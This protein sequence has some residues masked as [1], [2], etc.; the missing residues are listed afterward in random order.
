L[1]G[2][3]VINKFLK[4]LSVLAL[5]TSSATA[6]AQAASA[7]GV[8]RKLDLDAQRVLIKHGEWQGVSMSPMTMPFQVRDKAML[9]DLKVNDTVHFSMVQDGRDWVI[10]QI[11]RLEP[12]ISGQ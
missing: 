7:D 12:A 9:Q 11:A 8:I 10:T 2:N 3:T 4:T 1:Q 5:A 6:S